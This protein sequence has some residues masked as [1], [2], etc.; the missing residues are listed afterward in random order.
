MIS[1]ENTEQPEGF[2][3]LET[4]SI[5]TELDLRLLCVV[6]YADVWPLPVDVVLQLVAVSSLVLEPVLDLLRLDGDLRLETR[7]Q[8]R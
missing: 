5:T 8:L 1:S 7:A 6:W 3:E 4:A 2:G